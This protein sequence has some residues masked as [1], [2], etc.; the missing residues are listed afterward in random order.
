MI[1]YIY[2]HTHISPGVGLKPRP[3]VV[4]LEAMQPRAVGRTVLQS[5]PLVSQRPSVLEVESL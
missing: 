1:I 4:R 2:I 3:C 5:R